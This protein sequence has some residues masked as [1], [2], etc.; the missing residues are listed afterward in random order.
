M[1]WANESNCKLFDVCEKVQKSFS[2]D[3][4]GGKFSVL[5]ALSDEDLLRCNQLYMVDVLERTLVP[6]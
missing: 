6:T 3:V 5:L 2:M 4:V 1:C